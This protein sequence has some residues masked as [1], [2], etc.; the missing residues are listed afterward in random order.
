MQNFLTIKQLIEQLEKYPH[1]SLVLV[2]GYE[3]GLDAILSTKLVNIDYAENQKW[4]YGPF[5]ESDK[6]DRKAVK[7]I[8]TRGTRA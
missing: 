1:D 6:I 8:S 4:W 5:N 7:L 3:D 2:D